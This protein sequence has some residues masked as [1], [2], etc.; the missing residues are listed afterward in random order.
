MMG[1][2]VALPILHI[3]YRSQALRLS[4]D[5]RFKTAKAVLLQVHKILVYNDEHTAW[6][7]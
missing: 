3:F 2:A 5:Q 7:R 6:K 4:T 1:F